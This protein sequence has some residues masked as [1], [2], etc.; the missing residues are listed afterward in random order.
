MKK[1]ITSAKSPRQTKEAIRKSN[2]V[3]IAM[4]LGDKTSRY[5]VLNEGGEVVAEGSAASTQKGM[6]Q[7]FGTIPRCRI[8][9]EVGTHSPWISRLL[10][11]VGHEVIAVSY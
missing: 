4:D 11:R 3:T 5:C 8:A 6:L 10:N 1:N 9:I 2:R 7:T